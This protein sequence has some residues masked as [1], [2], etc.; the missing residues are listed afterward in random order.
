MREYRSTRMAHYLRASLERAK[1]VCRK[2]SGTVAR[3]M[4]VWVLSICRKVPPSESLFL[5][6]ALMVM[7]RRAHAGAAGFPSNHR[8]VV[9]PSR[10][11][12]G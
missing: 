3:I 9:K 8:H 5:N 11:Y 10:T 2:G 12:N 6:M 1:G 7:D 4:P